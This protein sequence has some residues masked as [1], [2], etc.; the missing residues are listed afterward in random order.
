MTTVILPINGY[1]KNKFKKLWNL[2][3]LLNKQYLGF[4][5]HEEVGAHV[6]GLNTIKR[7]LLYA[8]KAPDTS[9][10]LIIDLNKLQAC[11]IIKEYRSIDAGELRTKKL[12]H[13]LK[14]IFLN[15]VFKNGSGTVS[16]PLFNAEKERQDNL[17]E[18]EAQAKKWEQIVQHYC[19]FT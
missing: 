6:I 14:T 10:C 12:H 4:P 16:L 17:E 11:S 5:K 15:L 7:K 19:G 9:S 2:R 13:F 18:L 3:P 8:K 1:L